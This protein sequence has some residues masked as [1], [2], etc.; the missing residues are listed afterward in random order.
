MG[1][2][3]VPVLAPHAVPEHAGPE[4][5]PGEAPRVVRPI[6][7]T[8]V[9]R[10]VSL[11]AWVAL[12]I[13]YV[14]WGGTYLG[15]R[16][17]DETIPPLVLAATRFVIAGAIMFP[18]ALRNAGSAAR[19]A[20]QAG[21]YW[22]R[23]SEWLGCVIVGILLVGANAAVC[24]GETTVPSGLAALLIATVPLWLLGIDA[25]LN[26]ARLGLAQAAGL[27]V[28]LAG[29]GLLSGLG[30]GKGGVSASG[31][32]IILCAAAS[33]ATGTI[34]SRRVPTPASPALTSAMQLLIGGVFS[35]VLAAASGEFGSFRLSAVSDRSWL[36]LAYLIVG[37]SIV[38]FSAYVIAVRLLPTA[39]V[40]TYAYVNPVIAVL[41][42]TL[43][44]NE[45][46]SVGMLAG[47][48]LIVGAVVLV[49]RRSPPAH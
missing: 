37:G 39:T 28:G 26:H 18:V 44:L 49:V 20:G 42:G 34:M 6:E 8:G 35:L 15:M 9:V 16:V 11:R 33:W 10:R 24:V 7:K 47:G 38:A 22:P 19:A 2:R 25:L 43:I 1:M 4:A 21:P 14:F 46:V 48:A 30:G 41:L 29:V 23:R 31:V 40:A 32:V 36:A 3:K 45:R 17:G 5:G 13:V 12:L 27:A